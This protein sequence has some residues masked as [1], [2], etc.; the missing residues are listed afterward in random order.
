MR[1][2]GFD[3]YGACRIIRD[4]NSSNLC[5]SDIFWRNSDVDKV[6]YRMKRQLMIQSF[7]PLF[8]L[9][10]IKYFEFEIIDDIVSAVAAFKE[11]EWMILIHMWGHESFYNLLFLLSLL[12]M[13]ADGAISIW[14]FR[15]LQKSAPYDT[16]EKV[17]IEEELTETSPT[18]FATFILPLLYDDLNTPRGMVIFIGIMGG[19]FVLMW[20]TDLYYQNPVLTILG[21]RIY[22]GEFINP[23]CEENQNK[24]FVFITYSTFDQSRIICRQYISGDVYLVMNKK[25]IYARR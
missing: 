24:K 19:L 22:K 18:F 17:K 8:I 9:L 5:D 21:Y 14:Q 16:G 15:S 1:G 2:G 7:L 25:V 23:I 20:R 13:I 11:T 10:F 3:V 4:Y 12:V 6:N